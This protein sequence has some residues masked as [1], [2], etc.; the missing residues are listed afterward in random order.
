MGAEGA[1]GPGGWGAN[2]ERH[3]GR[4]RDRGRAGRDELFRGR[5]R[6]VGELQLAAAGRHQNVLQ[7]AAGALRSEDP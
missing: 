7:S 3:E 2:K 4:A 1:G 6:T 5:A